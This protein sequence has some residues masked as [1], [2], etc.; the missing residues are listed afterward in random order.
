[1]EEIYGSAK[2]SN[3]NCADW[4]SDLWFSHN[5]HV[6]SAFFW[7]SFNFCY[8][9]WSLVRRWLRKHDS[10]QLVDDSRLGDISV[11]QM[12]VVFSM[13]HDQDWKFIRLQLRDSFN[14]FSMTQNVLEQKKKTK[15]YR[16][17]NRVFLSL[18]TLIVNSAVFQIDRNI[19]AI[20][21]YKH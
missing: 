6:F 11:N 4:K 20:F 8:V 17:L 2:A 9:L 1:M 5:S 10:Y 7:V 3:E 19:M 14:L 12:S 18:N 21:L 15:S 13:N 16:K